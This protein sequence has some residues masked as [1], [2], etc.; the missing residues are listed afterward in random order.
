MV[1]PTII[2]CASGWLSA[3]LL[4]DTH[5]PCLPLPWRDLGDHAEDRRP[6]DVQPSSDLVGIEAPW[7]QSAAGSTGLS[8]TTAPASFHCGPTSR[9]AAASETA[10]ITELSRTT[11]RRTTAA[12]RPGGS[13]SRQCTTTA[14][15]A[16]NP[17]TNSAAR[18]ELAWTTSGRSRRTCARSARRALSA[19]TSSRELAAHLKPERQLA[20]GN[21]INRDAERDGKPSQWAR[22]TCKHH[23]VLLAKHAH[24]LKQRA[25]SSADDARML[26][27]QNPQWSVAPVRGSYRFGPGS[28]SLRIGRQLRVEPRSGPAL[29]ASRTTS[30]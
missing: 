21:R 5:G 30:S 18:K 9:A 25:L 2:S 6:V 22:R 28:S 7:G 13:R 4:E 29:G 1:S 11:A 10:M 3:H 19:C 23:L 8:M 12:A 16:P 27:E 24:E 14:V 17:P 15:F 20:V 26:D